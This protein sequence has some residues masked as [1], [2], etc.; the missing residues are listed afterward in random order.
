MRFHRRRRC[1]IVSKIKTMTDKKSTY[2]RLLS[3]TGHILIL[4][5]KKDVLLHKSTRRPF[6][7]LLSRAH[8][9]TH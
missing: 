1:N 9:V 5:L 2:V 6:R 3:V 4:P 8:M 7:I